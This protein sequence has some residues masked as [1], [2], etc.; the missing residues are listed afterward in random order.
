MAENPNDNKQ[1]P[2]RRGLLRDIFDKGIKDGTIKRE[3]NG[4]V[5]PSGKM[6]I[7]AVFSE[8]SPKPISLEGDGIRVKAPKF[9]PQT[10]PELV[11]KVEKGEP[12]KQV[13]LPQASDIQS[14]APQRKLSKAEI[15]ENREKYFPNAIENTLT[16]Q[17]QIKRILITW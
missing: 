9:V 16:I 15:E 5:E 10:K 1:Q 7:P 14:L 8:R 4:R 11:G 6:P 12:V 17:L 3:S 13:V 2:I